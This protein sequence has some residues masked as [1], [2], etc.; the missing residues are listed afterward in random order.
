MRCEE[1]RQLIPD[2]VLGT[3]SETESAAVRRHMRGCSACRTEAADLDEGVALFAQAAHAAEPPSELKGKVMALLE[4]EWA[5]APTPRGGRI[6]RFALGW[7]AAAAILTVLAGVTTWGG[8]AQINSNRDRGDARTYRGILIALGGKE[9]RVGR[10]VATPGVAM[11]GRVILYDSDHEQSWMM[12]LASAPGF[13]EPLTVS[14]EAPDRSIEVPFPL[15]F[16]P[17][18]KGWSGLV[19]ST[20]ISDVD[21]VL[22]RDPAGRVIARAVIPTE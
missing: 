3:L 4:E 16:E 1:V 19:T 14:L 5:D 12:L 22:L 15:K 2:Y 7:Q 20:D 21:L 9:M 13:S 18:G 6:R 10:L 17:D 8:I 11:E